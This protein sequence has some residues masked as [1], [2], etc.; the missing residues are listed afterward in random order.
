M[1]F[2]AATMVVFFHSTQAVNHYFGGGITPAIA[3]AANFGASGVHIF[4]V[5]SGFIMVYSSFPNKSAQFSAQKFYLRR[6]IRIYPIYW[7]DCVLYLAFHTY[8]GQGYALSSGQIAGSLMLLPGYSTLIIGPG[9]TLSYEVYFYICF[10]IAMSLGLER[11]LVLLLVFFLMSIIAGI[12]F[13]TEN[14]VVQVLTNTLLI[15]FLLG[16]GIGYFI[17][18]GRTLTVSIAYA[19]QALALAAFFLGYLIGYSRLP[20]VVMWG[21]PSSILLFGLIANERNGHLF[22]WIKRLSFLGD[23]SYSV[24]LIHVLLIDVLLSTYLKMFPAPGHGGLRMSILLT[25]LII[26]IAYVFYELLER[27]LLVAF[28]NMNSQAKARSGDLP[29]WQATGLTTSF[30]LRRGAHDERRSEK[31]FQAGRVETSSVYDLGSASNGDT[32]SRASIG[33][34]VVT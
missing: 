21:V 27:N 31:V 13:G 25:A 19:L 33:Y 32:A 34:E 8:F 22:Y 3:Y 14:S 10:G 6:F 4:F 16:A 28:H 12:G 5:I 2:V 1:R 11:G 24:Y 23:S 26:G 7:I 9:W 17:L 20:S 30:G 18:A 15:E 29:P